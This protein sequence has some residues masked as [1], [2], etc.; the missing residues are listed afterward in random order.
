MQVND[1]KGNN[2]RGGVGVRISTSDED[3]YGVKRWAKDLFWGTV[4]LR[5]YE[6]G[7]WGHGG[8]HNSKVKVISNQ[9]CGK[10]LSDSN[11]Y[12]S[13]IHKRGIGHVFTG[14]DTFSCKRGI[15][16]GWPCSVCVHA[17]GDP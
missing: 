8:L 4:I 9:M 6:E 17:T 12:S 14:C 2:K 15:G 16:G 10:I 13:V 11:W 5:P 3:V 1:G 7:S